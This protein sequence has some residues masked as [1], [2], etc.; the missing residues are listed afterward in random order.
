MT[1]SRLVRVILGAVAL[2]AVALPSLT[3]ASGDAATQT[4]ERRPS[5]PPNVMFPV[6]S[7]LAKDLR[8]GG[9]TP[10]T[11]IAAPCGA[12]VRAAHAGTA[13]VGHSPTAGNLVRIETTRGQLSTWYG[14]MSR[15]VVANGQLIQA[16]QAIG[17]VGHTGTAARRCSLYFAVNGNHNERWNPSSFLSLYVGK[18]APM[19]SMFG[20]GGFTVASFNVLG[21]DHTPKPG[22]A[23]YQTRTPAMV[24]TLANYHVDVA[25]LQE[26]Q[27][28]QYDLFKQLTGSTYGVWTGRLDGTPVN[29]IIW[30]NSTFEFITGSYV[31]IPYFRGTPIRMPVVELRHRASGRIAWF[32]NVHNPASISPYGDQ[33]KFRAQAI[34][35]EKAK[36][37]E[38][39]K[40]GHAVF[41]TGDF[42]DRLPAYCPLTANKLTITPDGIPST[43]CAPPKSVGIDWIFVAGPAR[44]KS[45]ARDWAPKNAGVTD[46]PIV[47]ARAYLQ[48]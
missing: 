22:Y 6:V 1:S 41:L 30:R 34:A 28:P 31:T 4:Y 19:A 39:R 44:Y 13:Y 38:L 35:I 15:V 25:G 26:F 43:T 42:N 46:H 2:G 33:S 8:T 47:W 12:Q 37:V 36:I 45:W 27:K 16:G 10:G 23:G 7:R 9:R 29:S 40:T 21:A 14:F 18:P 3:V 17:Q 32:I 20:N 48:H 24:K 5:T 11:Q